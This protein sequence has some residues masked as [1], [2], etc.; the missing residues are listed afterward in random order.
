MNVKKFSAG[1]G[2]L[3]LCLSGL[4]LAGC[5]GSLKVVAPEVDDAAAI[6]SISSF[7][8]EPVQYDVE[9]EPDWELSDSEWKTRT[10]DWSNQFAE[11]CTSADKAVYTGTAAPEGG[12]K[13][14]LLITSMNLGTYAFFYKAPGWIRG[15]LT[16]KDS[17]GTVIFRGAVD[18]PGTTEG[19]ERYSL[20]GR[21]EVAHSRVA[22]DVRWLIN[23]TLD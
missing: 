19:H 15:I 6:A 20:E 23:R 22:R 5:G 3:M 8:I 17:K 4:L 11:K 9:R 12:A 2:A 7:Y 10:N 1:F 14:E 13:V 16:I 21:I 18:S